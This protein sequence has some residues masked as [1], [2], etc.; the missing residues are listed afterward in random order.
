M[1][2]GVFRWWKEDRRELLPYLLLLIVFPIPY[3]LTH[4]SMD[5]R[6]PIEPQIIVLVA[7]GIFGFKDWIATA[8]SRE[9][10]DARPYQ[11]GPVMA[12]RFKEKS[13]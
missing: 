9:V 13:L 7:I 12:Y 2:R 6:Q 11:A 4:S 3:Y 10:E 1:L 8:E 5:Y